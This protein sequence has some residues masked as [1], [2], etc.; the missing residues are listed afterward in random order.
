MRESERRIE[1]E[2][3]RVEDYREATIRDYRLA[4]DAA[5]NDY[6][7]TKALDAYDAPCASPTETNVHASG[8]R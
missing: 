1:E 2:K 5:Y 3:Q 4:G 6:A 7:F 8:P